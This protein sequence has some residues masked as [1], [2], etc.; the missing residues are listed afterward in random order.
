MSHTC[1]CHLNDYSN[2]LVLFEKYDVVTRNVRS[3][4][5]WII[6][7][8]SLLIEHLAHVKAKLLT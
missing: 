7:N 6:S 1:C 5:K 2:T 8:V 3:Q 4:Q